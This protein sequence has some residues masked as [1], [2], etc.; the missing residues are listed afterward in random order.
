MNRAHGRATG[1]KDDDWVW[2]E[3]PLGP[4]QGAAPADGGRERNTV[5]TWNAIGKRAGAWDLEP[6]APEATQGFLLNHVIAELLP[7][8]EG[9]RH[10]NC[11]SDHR[12]GGVVRPRVRVPRPRPRKPA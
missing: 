8:T 11:R 6:A 7:S 3:S 9:Y 12:P 1:L 5:W 2:I 10:A 4:R